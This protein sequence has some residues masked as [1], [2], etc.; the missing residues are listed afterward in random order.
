MRKVVLQVLLAAATLAASIAPVMAA[1]DSYLVF[2]GTYTNKGSQGIYAWKFNA[3]KGR[4]ES[5]GLVG[6]TTSPS[7]LALHPNQTT[8]YAVNETGNFQGQKSGAVSAFQI[9]PQTGKLKLINQV[10]SHG[11]GPCHVEA[12]AT[13]KTLA[14]ANYGGGNFTWYPLRSDGGIGDSFT[15]I[16]NQGGGPVQSRQEGPHGHSVNFAPDNRHMLAVDLGTDSILNSS[17][18]ATTGQLAAATPARISTKPG[19]GPRHLVFSA[20]GKHCYVINEIDSTVVAYA[21]DA[22]TGDLK[23]LQRL[24]TLPAGFTGENSTAEIALHPSGRF[25]YGSNRG[26]DSMAGTVPSGGKTPRGFAIEPKGRF[27]FAANQDSDNITVF[28]VSEKTGL[29]KPTGTVLSVST[30]VNVLFL[31]VR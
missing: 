21:Y 30:P 16:S 25:L 23:E 4:A 9:N 1:S 17:Y 8:L 7:F 10:S 27:L 19:S 22:D 28:R 5:V 29:L 6:T 26:H 12:D 15:V 31:P 2:A 18:D 11:D 24:S 3:A 14:V 20:D 13:G